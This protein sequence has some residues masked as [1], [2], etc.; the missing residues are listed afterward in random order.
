[1]LGWSGEGALLL[2]VSARVHWLSGFCVE[3][4]GPE[5]R[6]VCGGM[7]RTHPPH[8][9]HDSDNV[10][11]VNSLIKTHKLLFSFAEMKSLLCPLQMI[12]LLR[13]F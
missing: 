8:P 11:M 5:D 6:T 4:V 12:K 9:G 10:C 7:A 3:E 1:M 2:S 13:C